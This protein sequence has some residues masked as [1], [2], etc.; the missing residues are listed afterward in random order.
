MINC[1]LYRDITISTGES[2]CMLVDVNVGIQD[3]LYIFNLDDI[4]GLVFSGDSRPDASLFVDTIITSQPFYRIDATNL[5]YT[6][7]Y[8][9]HYYHQTLT[10]SIISV[11]NEIEEIME[12]AVHGRYVI[13]FKVIGNEH[14]KL[15][16]WK[17]G[18]SLDDELTIASED[19]SF[20]LTF[21]GN[22]TWPMMEADKSNFNLANKVFEPTFEPLFE[23][24]KVV[25]HDNGW[26]TAMYVVKVNAAGQP[27]D[28]NN[29][30]CQYSLLPQDAYKLQG[31]ADGG[32]HI[33]GTY[34]TNDFIEGKAVDIYDTSLCN[35]SG[36]ITVTPSTVNLNSNI[37]TSAITVVSSQE[38]EL[39]TY[40]SFLQISRTGGGVNDQLV[41]IYGTDICGS[42]ILTFRNRVTRQTANLTVHN[43]RIG[44]GSN[45]T[46]PNGTTNFTLTPTICGTYTATASSGTVTINGDGSFTVTGLSVSNNEQTITVTL[47]AGTETKQVTI[48]ILGNNT[49]PMLRAIAEW[50]QT[51]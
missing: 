32:Y 47:T 8:E 1:R 41:Y 27:L 51:E 29:K 34:T 22:T 4:E 20:Q 26:A 36:S 49:A 10:A 24:G 30:L 2:G 42:E 17:E 21:D 3:G 39:V 5:N 7:E 15:I 50:C 6:E 9:D 37:T 46:Y 23:V 25:C 18:L 43:D 48:T 44:I 14:Y 40:P 45:Y 31:V 16:G 33:I 35:V 19:N 28:T 12:A 13:A 38:W 11:R